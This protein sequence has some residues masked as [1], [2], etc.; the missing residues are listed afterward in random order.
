MTVLDQDTT[1]VRRQT[2]ERLVERYR[3][4]D[5]GHREVDVRAA[6]ADAFG[7]LS[8]ARVTS[9]VPVLVERSVRRTLTL[10]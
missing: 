8:G 4:A 10:R 9:F 7:R 1:D 5:R 2:E 3:T 6:V